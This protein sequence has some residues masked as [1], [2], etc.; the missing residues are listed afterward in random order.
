[1]ATKKKTTTEA[2]VDTTAST[3]EVNEPIIE[4]PKIKAVR[5][6]RPKLDLNEM[7]FVS[8]GF[9]GN[10]TYKSRK[11]GY[12]FKLSHF[13]DGD[14]IELGELL[15]AKNAEPKFFE[16]NWFVIDDPDVLAFLNVEKYY[17]KYLDP[18]QFSTLFDLTPDEVKDKVAQLSKGQKASLTYRALEMIET[19]ELDSRRM[20]AALEEALEVQ[21]VEQ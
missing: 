11:T 8:N 7:V 15:T 1:M 3:T 6:A 5:K 17:E 9:Y 4:E 10:L 2:A 20:I 14:Y 12:T 13:G 21:L 19:G 16:N 18:E